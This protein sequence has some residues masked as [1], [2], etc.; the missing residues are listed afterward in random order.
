MTARDLEVIREACIYVGK[1]KPARIQKGM[2]RLARMAKQNGLSDDC[3]M[4]VWTARFKLQN[5]GN[6]MAAFTMLNKVLSL[7]GK[8]VAE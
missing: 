3:R 8:A 1:L 5:T 7:N 2:N 4:Y 6:A